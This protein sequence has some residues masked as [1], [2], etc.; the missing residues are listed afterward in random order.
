[1]FLKVHAVRNPSQDSL[2]ILVAGD[3]DAY[4]VV[5]ARDSALTVRQGQKETQEE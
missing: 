2:V 5:G 1:M 4:F 3:Q